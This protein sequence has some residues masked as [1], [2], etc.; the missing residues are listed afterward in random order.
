MPHRL[1]EALFSAIFVTNICIHR[2]RIQQFYFLYHI[3]FVGTRDVEAEAGRVEAVL[4][5]CKRKRENS[6]ASA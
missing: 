3:M 2:I 4:F 5:L 6:T 1:T